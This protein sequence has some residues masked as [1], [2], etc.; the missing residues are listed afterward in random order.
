MTDRLLTPEYLGALCLRKF[1][2]WTQQYITHYEPIYSRQ[3][4]MVA[5]DL[6]WQAEGQKHTRALMG[7]RYVSTL[8]WWRAEDQGK[9]QREVTVSNWLKEQ[10]FPAAQALTREFDAQGDVVLFERL[11]GYDWSK[12]GRSFPEVIGPRAREFARLLIRL[13]SLQPSET[14]IAVVPSVSLPKAL[15]NLTALGDRIALTR[16][17]QIIERIMTPAFTLKE[18]I[19]VLLH[20]DYHFSNAV[21]HEDRISGIIDWEFCGLGDPRWDVANAYM[22]LVDFGAANAAAAFLDEYLQGSGRKFDQSPLFNIVASLQQWAVSEWLVQRYSQGT[23]PDFAM[24]D[25]LVIQRDTHRQRAE[26]ALHML[27]DA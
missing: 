6:T 16:L 9:A 14:I 11:P 19:P 26:M 15:A 22:Q 23:L 21:L 25:D 7:R 10:G 5:F 8:S 13:H 3:H 1:P 27:N 20:G 2:D 12:A 17:K 24:A 4:E 18:A